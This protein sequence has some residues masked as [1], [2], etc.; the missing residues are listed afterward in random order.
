MSRFFWWNFFVLAVVGMFVAA[1][2]FIVAI[3]A[4]LTTTNPWWLVGVIGL[5]A[6]ITLGYVAWHAAGR[7]L[8]PAR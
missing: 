5:P 6:A 8:E 1:G 3:P 4:A 7:V 2:A